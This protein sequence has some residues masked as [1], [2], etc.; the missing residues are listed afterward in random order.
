[1]LLDS[2]PEVLL[3]EGHMEGTKGWSSY[4]SLQDT[5]PLG[6]PLQSGPYLH[7]CTPAGTSAWEPAAMPSSHLLPWA[8]VR[9]KKGTQTWC[10]SAQMTKKTIS[11]YKVA[12]FTGHRIPPL[13]ALIPQGCCS[14]GHFGRTLGF[15]KY[16]KLFTWMRKASKAWCCARGVCAITSFINRN[17]G[18]GKPDVLSGTIRL[19]PLTF[20]LVSLSLFPQRRTPKGCNSQFPNL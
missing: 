19:F 1:M 9:K 16:I 12:I 7:P 10:A 18:A 3:E 8:A 5:F 11:S 2:S 17:S 13:A 14:T 15:S 6:Q 20:S 4:R